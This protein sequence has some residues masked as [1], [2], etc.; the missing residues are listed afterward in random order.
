[1]ERMWEQC[2]QCAG[3]T[4]PCL[5]STVPSLMTGCSAEWAL[6]CQDSK[7]SC[8]L[9]VNKALTDS[10]IC[11][12]ATK[13]VTPAF[14]PPHCRVVYHEGSSH[15]RVQRLMLVR[16]SCTELPLTSKEMAEQNPTVWGATSSIWSESG[17]FFSFSLYKWLNLQ[18]EYVMSTFHSSGLWIVRCTYTYWGAR[19]WT[20]FYRREGRGCVLEKSI[21]IPCFPWSARPPRDQVT[22]AGLMAHFT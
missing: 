14:P 7:R 8:L 17:Q 9:G 18:T 1:M 21:P 10:G 11:R 5:P 4:L 3:W 22:G 12:A 2:P 15:L 16:P 6:V 19:R 13:C 20:A